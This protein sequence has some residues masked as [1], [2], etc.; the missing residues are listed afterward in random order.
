MAYEIHELSPEELHWRLK[1]VVHQQRPQKE[2]G[3]EPIGLS[4]ITCNAIA[5]SDIPERAIT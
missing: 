1:F 4:K 3:D 5:S 2:A